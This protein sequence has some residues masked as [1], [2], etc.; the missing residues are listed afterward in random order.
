M[1]ENMDRTFGLVFS[2]R[3]LLMI[4]DKGASR[5]EA[6]DIIQPLAMQAWREKRMFRDLV[7]KSTEVSRWLSAEEV[8]EAFDYSYHMKSVDTIF[9]RAGIK[10]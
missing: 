1:K 6:Y 8:A 4:I 9:K 3:L 7:E 5:E 2:Q 10:G